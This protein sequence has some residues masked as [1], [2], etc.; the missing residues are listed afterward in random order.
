VAFLV[1]INQGL[2]LLGSEGL[3]P[4]PDHLDRYLQHQ[5]GFTDAFLGKPTVFLWFYS[6]T[7]F[8][9]LAWFGLGLSVLLMIGFDNMIILFVLWALYLSY[10]NVG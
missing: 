2:P 8:Q 5:S 4:V 10:V 9:A 1:I 6:D 3:L 7:L